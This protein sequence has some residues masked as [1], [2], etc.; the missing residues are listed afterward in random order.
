MG[1][2]AVLAGASGVPLWGVFRGGGVVGAEGT[3]EAVAKNK[4]SYTGM[5]LA[6]SLKG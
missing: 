5:F 3:P 1:G 2:A 4:A 6:D